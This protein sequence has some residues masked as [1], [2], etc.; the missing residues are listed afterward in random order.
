VHR[1]SVAGCLLLAGCGCDHGVFGDPFPIAVDMT[2]GPVIA[3]V[4]EGD[5]AL[6]AAVIDVLAPLTELDAADGAAGSSRRCTDLTLYGVGSPADPGALVPRAHL[7]LT[8]TAQALC[9]GTDGT[10]VPCEIPV[11]GGTPISIGALIGGDAFDPGAIRFDFVAGAITLF[12]EVAGDDEARGQ[13]CEA[14]IQR[15][16]RGGGTLFL[17]GTEVSFPRRRIAFGA[18]LSYPD[19]GDPATPDIEE[20]GAN[21]ELVLSTGIGTTI[22]SE[23]A[24]ERW[25]AASGTG[26]PVSALPAGSVWL[27]SG[28]VEGVT[29]QI[30]R[31]AVVGRDDDDRGPCRQ[32]YAH[33][34]LTERDC[35]PDDE[36]PC[37]DGADS[38]S[39]PAIL[40]LAPAAKLDVLIV[41]DD[42]LTLQALRAELRPDTAEIDGILG[43]AAL[44]PT[45]IDVEYEV[46]HERML[47]RCLGPGCVARPALATSDQRPLV[48]ACLAREVPASADAGVP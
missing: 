26:D 31:I 33:H 27:P 37:T 41:P 29:G 35:G 13:L 8:V 6:R 38:C 47:M 40:E 14:Q 2:H 36:C 43:T 19:D 21:V 20:H 30:D 23:T 34:L 9:T 18:C 42:D 46:A 45:S 44:A 11:P 7:D 24:Y 1:L 3:Y 25:R 32:V 5:G 16:F 28:P 10:A 12:S 48:K 4:S 22:L 39:V 17:G 15:P